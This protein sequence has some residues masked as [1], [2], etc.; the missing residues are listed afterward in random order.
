LLPGSKR[1]THKQ[2]VLSKTHPSSNQ[3]L[4]FVIIETGFWKYP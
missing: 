4:I 1:L 3:P 2:K